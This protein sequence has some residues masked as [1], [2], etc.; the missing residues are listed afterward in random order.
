M[1]K[2]E[3]VEKVR[4]YTAKIEHL[5]E[6]RRLFIDAY[7]AEHI[8]FEASMKSPVLCEVEYDYEN[9]PLDIN[10]PN[11]TVKGVVHVV[12][13]EGAAWYG[14]QWEGYIIPRMVRINGE[15]SLY[16][17]EPVHFRLGANFDTLKV[18]PVVELKDETSTETDAQSDQATVPDHSESE[19]DL[20]PESDPKLL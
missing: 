7:E 3:Y 1:D 8:P 4:E 10:F 6:E 15:G 14:E 11:G 18:T 16:H 17:K 13:W 19:S 20:Q 2:K 12:G 9:N 5:E